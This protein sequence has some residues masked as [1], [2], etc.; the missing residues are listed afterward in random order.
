MKLDQESRLV[1]RCRRG[2][3]R[4]WD[5]LFDLFYG[6][7]SRFIFQIS[8]EFTREDSEEIAQ[9]TFLSVIRNIGHYRGESQLQTWIFRIASNKARDFR[10]RKVAA[11]RGG[12]L[13]PIS[14]QAE[15]PETG[16]TADPASPLPSPDEI[17]LR[18]ENCSLIGLALQHLEPPCREVIELRYFADLSYE[19]ISK[20]LQ[21]NQ[22]TVSSRLSRC[23]DR[24]EKI[25]SSL[26]S[27]KKSDPFPV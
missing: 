10:E 4:A 24:L 20:E 6:P 8:P 14:L 7:V 1:A 23:L 21:V 13:T 3:S 11:K 19:E 22:K 17:L 12:G 15:D 26:F 27:G 16:L 18:T 9:D 25:A 5:E 2:E